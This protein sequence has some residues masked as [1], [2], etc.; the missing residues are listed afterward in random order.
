M[1]FLNVIGIWLHGSGWCKGKITSGRV[2][3]FLKGSHV[4]RSRYA[5]QIILAA[6]I[7]SAH[8]AYLET[9]YSY[10]DDW[11]KSVME[12]SNNAFYWFCVLELQLNLFLF[13]RSISKENFDLFVRTVDTMLSWAFALAYINYAR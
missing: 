10:H 2:H 7:K 9:D 4:K 12:S 13:I 5:Q 1:M 8:Q 3:S 11:K 6:L